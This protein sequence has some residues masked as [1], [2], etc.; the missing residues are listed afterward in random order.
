MAVDDHGSS[1]ASG[2][3]ATS[4]HRGGTRETSLSDFS[5]ARNLRPDAMRRGDFTILIAAPWTGLRS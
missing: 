1:Q 3:S 5:P 2:V 4:G